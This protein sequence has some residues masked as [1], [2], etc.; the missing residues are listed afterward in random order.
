MRY[1]ITDVRFN[2]FMTLKTIFTDICVMF[3]LY[4][5]LDFRYIAFE[6]TVRYI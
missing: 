6:N 5:K 4:T 3:V 2:S 1:K